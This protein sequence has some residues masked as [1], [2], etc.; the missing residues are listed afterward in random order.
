[1]IFRIDDFLSDELVRRVL[2]LRFVNRVFEPIW[3]AVHVDHVEISWRESLT[4]EGR[5]SYYDRAGA[6]KDMVQNHLM[7][8]MALILM[9]QPTRLD[10]D[11][12]RG[13]WVEGLRAAAH[14]GDRGDAHPT[15]RA[16]CTV[17]TIGTRQVPSYV[18]E[19]GVDSSRNTE[20]YACMTVE[21]H[22]PRWDGVPF[23]LR[24]GKALAVDSAE[25]AIHF[26]PLPRYL[27]DQC[28]ASNP[29]CS[30]WAWPS[31][32][33]GCPSPSTARSKPPRHGSSR[34]GPH[35]PGSPPT[36]RLILQML[37]SNPM[38]FIRG[39]EAEEAWRIIDPVMKAWTAGDVP[40]QEYP[41]GQTP[42]GPRPD[43][44]CRFPRPVPADPPHRRMCP[45]RG[46][47]FNLDR[48]TPLRRPVLSI[49]VA[50]A[51]RA[52]DRPGGRC[53]RAANRT[54]AVV[55]GLSCCR[56]ALAGWWRCWGIVRP[57]CIGGRLA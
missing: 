12:F 19:P 38:L 33:C 48:P 6:L 43:L 5:A 46:C 21:A 47:S 35:R 27:L 49:Q 9:E 8:A 29:T 45:P 23:T 15:I 51:I 20:S 17:G 52:S 4:L 36:P 14:P 24:S 54:V 56:L 44:T 16:R 7:E 34:H 25:I 32:P 57:A 28:P 13:A 11:S 50:A 26:R 53:R 3:N 1:V 30:E 2:A 31:P 55:P 42:P 37:N 41:A 18:D 39:D 40:V 10:A 22:S